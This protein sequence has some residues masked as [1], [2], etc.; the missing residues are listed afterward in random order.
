MPFAKS[1]HFFWY[2]SCE[3][4]STSAKNR[5]NVNLSVSKVHSDL[6]LVFIIF[7]FLH[8]L[9][10]ANSEYSSG[11]CLQAGGSLSRQN[12]AAREQAGSLGG[13]LG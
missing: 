13:R 9:S 4:V 2:L 5:D 12:T 6:L 8:V 10:A 11:A 1:C 7:D 3:Y